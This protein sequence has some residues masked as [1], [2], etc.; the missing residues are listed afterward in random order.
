MV[1]Y[2]LIHF[3]DFCRRKKYKK[4]SAAV[5]YKIFY[6]KSALIEIV[7]L[8]KKISTNQPLVEDYEIYIEEYWNFRKHILRAQGS[9]GLLRKKNEELKGCLL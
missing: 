3:L 2:K 6:L 5:A 7:F 1:F 4:S 9:Q 8:Y